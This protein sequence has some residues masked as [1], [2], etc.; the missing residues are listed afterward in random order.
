MPRPRRESPFADKDLRVLIAAALF[1]EAAVHA[2]GTWCANQLE[3]KVFASNALAVRKRKPGPRK[4][5]L[6]SEQF[7][8]TGLFKQ[9]LGA[10]VPTDDILDQLTPV[11]PGAQFKD[12][13]H[14]LL[15]KLLVEGEPG[16]LVAA[17]LMNQLPPA[18]RDCLHRAICGK[19]RGAFL[20]RR[21][22]D[23]LLALGGVEA[24]VLLI[25]SERCVEEH[26]IDAMR[27]LRVVFPRLVSQVPW[28]F[29]RWRALALRLRKVVGFSLYGGKWDP[30]DFDV[31]LNA[32]RS[33]LE[34]ICLPP[35]SL[36]KTPANW[37]AAVANDAAADTLARQLVYGGT[38]TS[39]AVYLE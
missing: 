8:P 4:P 36:V 9:M 21:R 28:L 27:A 29:I 22:Y 38:R 14:H 12:L 25:A 6:A 35:D 20:D 19:S 18:H 30:L 1:A 5:E 33:R 24:L 39:F 11:F 13:K 15:W 34:R 3:R 23:R 17:E 26:G 7:E 32:S 2:D 31:Y 16:N 37:R 10:R